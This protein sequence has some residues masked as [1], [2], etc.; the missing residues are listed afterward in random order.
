M[1]TPTTIDALLETILATRHPDAPPRFERLGKPH[2]A[3]FEAA[4]AHAG[5]RNLCMVAD[6]PGTDVRG[7]NGCGIDSALV[8]T[9][10]GR[11]DLGFDEG[12]APVWSLSNSTFVG[13]RPIPP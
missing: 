2:P 7:A 1:P 4:V 11:V 9:G 12:D 3:L 5:T 8:G 6:Q 13:A 10:L